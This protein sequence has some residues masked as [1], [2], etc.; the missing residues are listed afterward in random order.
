[1]QYNPDYDTIIIGGGFFGCGLAVFLKKSQGNNVV[2]LERETELL[3]RA[4]YANQA[5]V[6]NGYHYPRSILTA[7]RC[8]VN[9]PRFVEDYKECI[10]S[11]FEKYYAVGKIF[12]I[13]YTIARA[14]PV[15]SG[16][17][18]PGLGTYQLLKSTKVCRPCHIMALKYFSS[19]S[20]LV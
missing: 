11:E 6:H 18:S 8:R 5:R 13:K 1:M 2:V 16:R 9:F 10:F 3:Q 14:A 20:D 4:S 17:G 7:L 12:S 19:S 15:K